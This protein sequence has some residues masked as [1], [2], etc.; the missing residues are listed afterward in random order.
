MAKSKNRK[1]HKQKAQ[2]RNEKIQQDAKKRQK[3]QQMLM[4]Q[5]QLQ[6]EISKRENIVATIYRNKPEIAKEDENG[7]LV[8]NDSVLEYIDDVLCWKENKNPILAGLEPLENFSMYTE[9]LVNQFLQNI[10]H[11]EKQQQE[12]IENSG[13]TTELVEDLDAELGISDD[14][15][16]VLDEADTEIQMEEVEVEADVSETPTDNKTD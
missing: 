8:Y 15:E 7:L 3:F 10:Q 6:Q 5:F 16:L 2:K 14:F 11:K 9:E 4:E 13:M 1:K 12:A